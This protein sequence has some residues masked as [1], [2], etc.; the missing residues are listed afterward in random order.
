VEPLLAELP[1]WV[2]FKVDQNLTLNSIHEWNQQNPHNKF[3]ILVLGKV[4]AILEST[5]VQAGIKFIPD[6]PVPAQS[7]VSALVSLALLGT[8]RTGHNSSTGSSLLYP[9]R[10]FLQQNKK[11]PVLQRRLQQI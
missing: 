10:K 2:E 6:N 4:T 11:F 3:Y 8:V 1:P 5:V 9:P 7:L